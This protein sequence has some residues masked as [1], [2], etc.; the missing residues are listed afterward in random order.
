MLCGDKVVKD[1]VL[2][3]DGLIGAALMVALRS[4]GHAVESWDLKSGHDLREIPTTAFDP[5]DRIW[6]LAW[7]TGGAK[8]IAASQAQHAIFKNNCELAAR[9][10]D[11]LASRVRPFLF[12][13]SQLAAQTTA[14]GLTKRLG[15]HWAQQLGGKV[16]RLW[17]VYGWE[18][19]DIRSHVVTDL[20]LTAM[21]DRVVR[22]RTSGRERRRFLYKTDCVEALLALFE[23]EAFYADIAGPEWLAISD[24]AAEIGRQLSVRIEPGT[25]E[26]EEVILDPARL[27]AGWRPRV[28][29]RDGIAQVIAD[30]RAFLRDHGEPALRKTL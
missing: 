10:F 17:N 13:T 18:S 8:Y 21:R 1:L 2:G 25:G 19:P 23:S 16:A 12:A 28:T 24:V 5:Y 27:P 14:Y 29:L 9:V 7:D 26:G 3:G 11:A 30:A 6:F 15:E 4:R 22:L 20:V